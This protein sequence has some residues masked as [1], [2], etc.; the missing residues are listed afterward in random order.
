MKYK[1]AIL[2]LGSPGAYRLAD[3]AQALGHQ[4]I[5]SDFD[6]QTAKQDLFGADIF[7]PRISPRSYKY[8]MQLTKEYSS[9]NPDGVSAVSHAGIERSFDKFL[10][11]QQMVAAGTPTPTTFLIKNRRHMLAYKERLPLIIKP[12]SE[13]QGRNIFVARTAEAL[14]A[15]S[16]LLLDL[17]GSCIVQDF[18]E[19]SAGRD[20]RVFVIGNRV[21]AAMERQAPEGSDIANLSKGGSARAVSITAA[22]AAISVR[23][24]QLFETAY[25]GVDMLRTSHGPVILEVNVA[26]GLKIANVTAKDIP[27]AIIKQLISQKEQTHD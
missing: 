22:E 18:I 3:A 24:A 27:T 15:Y 7:I 13:N 14:R 9:R 23:A 2:T 11:Y 12:R 26:P 19:E 8:A 20:I 17:Y 1:I 5:L 25:A 10:A 6:S 16:G 4:A 21:V